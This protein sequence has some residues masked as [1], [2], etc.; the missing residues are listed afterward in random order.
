MIKV[1][2]LEGAIR[3]VENDLQARIEKGTLDALKAIALMAQSDAQRRILKG[4]KTG[5]VYK[6]GEITHRASALGEAPAN[7][8]GFLV[9]SI[10]IDI[11]QKL[12][13]DLRALAPH[14]IHLEYGTVA[15][16][17]RPFLRPAGEEAGKRSKE[18]FDV[19]IAAALK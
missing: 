15:M 12:Q 5:R 7:D 2:V 9:G 19:Y 10:R 6:R 14:A 16:A 3:E 18:V 4:P 8:L 11:T 13:V 1:S 17:A